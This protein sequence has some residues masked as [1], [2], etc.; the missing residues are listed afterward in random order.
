MVLIYSQHL[1]SINA[2][3]SVEERHDIRIA[4]FFFILGWTYYMVATILMEGTIFMAM[5]MCVRTPRGYQP[6]LLLGS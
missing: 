4:A 3:N 1:V 5:R 2:E 6:F